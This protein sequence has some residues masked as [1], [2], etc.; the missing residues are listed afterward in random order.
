MYVFKPAFD[1]KV[2]YIKIILRNDCI[3]VSFHEDLA[4]Q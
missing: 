2:L 3:L 4:E 1:D